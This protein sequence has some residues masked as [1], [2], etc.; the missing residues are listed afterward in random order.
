MS[1]VTCLE[2][3]RTEDMDRCSKC[4]FHR[5]PDDV[6]TTYCRVPIYRGRKT[7]LERQLQVLRYRYREKERESR[8]C[9]T[10]GKLDQMETAREECRKIQQDAERLKEAI[11]AEEI[12]IGQAKAINDQAITA[13]E[14]LLY[15]HLK[16]ESVIRSI[17]S[18]KDL[19]S[20]LEFIREKKKDPAEL[21][22]EY[23]EF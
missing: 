15:E 23:F 19:N 13:V 5:L 2:T 17:M 12:M 8:I 7:A 18:G 9:M 11:H 6:S 10:R 21:A 14:E 1:T 22:R 20:F 4:F 16:T 3:G